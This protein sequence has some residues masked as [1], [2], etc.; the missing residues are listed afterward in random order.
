V[1]VTVQGHLGHERLRAVLRAALADRPEPLFSFG[2]GEVAS[3]IPAASV[4]TGSRRWV[5]AW[6]DAGLRPG[7]RIALDV[8]PSIAFLHVLVAGL[9]EGIT[10]V[11]CPPGSLDDAIARSGACLAVTA[12]DRAESTPTWFATSSEGP[13]VLDQPVSTGDRAASQSSLVLRGSCASR[14]L[15]WTSIIATDVVAMLESPT[16]TFDLASARVVSVLPWHDVDGIVTD[17]LGAIAGGAAVIHRTSGTSV[18]DIVDSADAIGGSHMSM[19]P[20]T[21]DLLAGDPRGLALL[22]RLD[23]GVV[24][25]ESV[26]SA[27]YGPAMPAPDGCRAHRSPDPDTRS[28][29]ELPL[30]RRILRQGSGSCAW[31]LRCEH[32]SEATG[33]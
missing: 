2:D 25:G 13:I 29:G 14:S 8:P 21:A 23:G 22:R 9:F 27:C 28:T 24:L 32:D 26:S 7:D 5:A 10:L 6:R 20:L 31:G 30:L 15:T 1:T 19:A 11:V 12:G 16:H 4:W 17:L 33:P 18:A 3:V